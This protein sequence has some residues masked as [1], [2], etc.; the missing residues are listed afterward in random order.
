MHRRNWRRLDVAAHCVAVDFKHLGV[1]FKLDITIH[2][3]TVDISAAALLNLDAAA[4]RGVSVDFHLGRAFGLDV[5]V[6]ADA[7]G[8]EGGACA[9]FD[10]A[11]YARAGEGAGCAVRHVDVVFRH[12]A[13]CAGASVIVSQGD[14][15]G[16]QTQAHSYECGDEER[17]KRTI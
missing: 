1:G 10:V 2:V 4:D 16:S 14:R 7:A 3:D 12:C 15:E 6:D 8:V 17:R 9:D 11:L 5:A 13:D